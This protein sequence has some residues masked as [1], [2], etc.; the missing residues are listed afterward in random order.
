M[1]LKLSFSK[2]DKSDAKQIADF[3]NAA[4]RGEFSRK[5]WTTEADLLDGLRTDTKQV[6]SLIED[7]NAMFI[8]CKMDFE[9]QGSVY[10]HNTDQCVHIG[11]LAVNPLQQN[12][13]IGKA[14]LQAAEI[15]SQQTWAVNRFVMSVISCRQ[16]LI[17]FYERRG[18]RRT[19]IS[20]EFPINPALWTPKVTDLR[21]ESLE[22]CV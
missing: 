15:S 8:L 10:L 19:G 16:E 1:N 20:E 2:A 12:R 9:L 11:M 13:G 17:A 6:F 4:Y 14:L 21:L 22:K 18:Y 5:G 3:V 7:N